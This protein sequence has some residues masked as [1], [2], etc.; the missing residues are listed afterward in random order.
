M[1]IQKP[2]TA[3][4]QAEAARTSILPSFL[5][6][7]FN[8]VGPNAELLRTS[9]SKLGVPTDLP[10]NEICHSRT[11]SDTRQSHGRLGH[12]NMP[13]ANEGSHEGKDTSL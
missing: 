2:R 7:D 12:S 3:A 1:M 5:P 6:R 10:A 8:A 11:I 9:I 13:V 4:K